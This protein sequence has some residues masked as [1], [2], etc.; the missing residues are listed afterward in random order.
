MSLFFSKSSDLFVHFQ[1]NREKLISLNDQETWYGFT[2]ISCRLEV[3]ALTTNTRLSPQDTESFSYPCLGDLEHNLCF[4]RCIA[5][6][7]FILASQ[8]IHSK[9]FLLKRSLSRVPLDLS[10]PFLQPRCIHALNMIN[11]SEDFKRFAMFL[12]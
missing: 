8:N 7:F 2:S 6:L 1:P 5:M 10:H 11:F 4:L 3:I 12:T 9:S